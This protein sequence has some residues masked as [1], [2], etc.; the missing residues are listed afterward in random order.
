MAKGDSVDLMMKFVLKGNTLKGES[1]TVLVK[2]GGES[3]ELINGFNLG[4]YSEI[5]RFTMRAGIR[6]E[7]PNAN[8][9]ANGV[10]RP[11]PPP[12]PPPVTRTIVGANGQRTT[13]I[14]QPPRPTASTRA[15]ATRGSYQSWREGTNRKGFPVDLAPVTFTR[16]I[17]KTSTTLIQAC[18]DSVSFDKISLIKRK[19]SGIEN[20]SG[21]VGSGDVFLR[22]DFIGCL[23][24]KVDWDNDDKVSETIDFICRTVSIHYR[25]QLPDGTLGRTKPGFYSI[26]GDPQPPMN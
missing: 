5:D 1:T 6:D 21:E 11:P 20:I 7:D 24:I 3:N 8:Q 15:I 17:D 18:I 19:S 14:I 13:Q 12:P 4:Y 10:E 16:I 26:V 25:P 23:I 9:A 22:V 2:P